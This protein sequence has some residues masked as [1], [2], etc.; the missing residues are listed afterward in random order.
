MTRKKNP[1]A[2]KRSSSLNNDRNIF[3]DAVSRLNSNNNNNDN[4]TYY[5]A[6]SHINTNSINKKNSTAQNKNSTASDGN[7]A[8]RA[9]VSGSINKKNSPR[10]IVSNKI[11]ANRAKGSGSIN[12]KNSPQQDIVSNKIQ[13]NRAKSSVEV[14]SDKEIEN[15]NKALISNDSKFQRFVKPTKKMVTLALEQNGKMGKRYH[16]EPFT[17][18]NDVFISM[19]KEIR[20]LKAKASLGAFS[21]A[22]RQ[23]L[24]NLQKHLRAK[25]AICSLA[26][27]TNKAR[28]SNPPRNNSASIVRARGH[29]FP[30]S[31]A[32]QGFTNSDAN[33]GVKNA[34]Y[35]HIMK[36]LSLFSNPY[37][38]L[39]NRPRVSD[40]RYLHW[41][42]TMR[43]ALDILKAKIQRFTPARPKKS[44]HWR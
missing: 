12:K 19:E 7:R 2:N 15:F 32:L 43:P 28:F 38:S 16:G 35:T 5:N 41:L 3:Y 11:Q 26:R 34:R 23:H 9:R 10:N 37:G 40:T 30:I 4:E 42:E 33:L 20:H 39:Y 13:A 29:E 14:I 27:L 22:E 21:T 25:G 44:S 31:L 36:A 18:N 8:N 24:V 1:A 6:I 17:C